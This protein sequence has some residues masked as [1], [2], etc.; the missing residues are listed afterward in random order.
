[1]SV[2]AGSLCL[3][4][5]EMSLKP[6]NVCAKCRRVGYCCV[7]CQKTAWPGHKL[8][9]KELVLRK[10][11]KKK[12][13]D[14]MRDKIRRFPKD[15]SYLYRLGTVLSGYGDEFALLYYDNEKPTKEEYLEA[16]M[17]FSKALE[18]KTGESDWE[19]SR[20]PV[21]KI[22]CDLMVGLA[23]AIKSSGTD[24]HMISFKD[25]E[26]IVR[27]YKAV[28]KYNPVH[29]SALLGYASLEAEIELEA[30]GFPRLY[31]NICSAQAAFDYASQK[32]PADESKQ[33]H[34][35]MLSTIL[36]H[37]AFNL[38]A[39]QVLD[40]YFYKF[41]HTDDAVICSFERQLVTDPYNIRALI[42]LIT[43]LNN[44]ADQQQQHLPE[45]HPVDKIFKLLETAAAVGPNREDAALLDVERRRYQHRKRYYGSRSFSFSK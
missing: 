27:L 32:D 3:G 33:L 21:D 30:S 26:A 19:T 6:L 35:T 42:D 16:K 15:P 34:L 10:E 40:R 12:V 45:S 11:G 18:L 23:D 8:A 22:T 38:Q 1:M 7:G 41:D 28:L 31:V 43:L 25:Y 5:Y 37:D 14:D 24:N 29:A 44:R 39:R 2:S 4:C 9:C 20:R 36:T 13:S 17:L